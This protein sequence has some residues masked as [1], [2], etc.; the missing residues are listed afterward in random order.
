M[1]FYET[2]KQRTAVHRQSSSSRHKGKRLTEDQVRLLEKSFSSTKKLD[3]ERKLQLA[4]ELG[5]PP[6]QVAIWYQNKRARWKTQTLEIDYNALQVKLESALSEKRGL[7]RDVERLQA[8]LRK[9]R[10]MLALT[11]LNQQV[12]EPNNNYDIN[13][14]NTTNNVI[15]CSNNASG[16]C[17][18]GGGSSSNNSFIINGDQRQHHRHV[19]CCW[20]EEEE[21][22]K[23]L[24][25]DD[26]YAC[27]MFANG[28]TRS[29][30]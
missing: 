9:A 1:D 2:Q 18:E 21:N 10:D 23:N 8:E 27:V 14:T 11:G 7:E 13:T 28:P 24:H 25:L 3:P 17:E 29:D 30:Y 22:N 5:V 15:S 20:E 19:S 26:L 4:G 12:Q 6:R 16:S